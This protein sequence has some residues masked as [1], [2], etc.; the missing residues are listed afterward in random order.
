MFLLV[1][2]LIGA[3]MAIAGLVK[4]ASFST[5]PLEHVPALIADKRTHISGGGN[6]SSATTKYFA[7]LERADGSRSEVDVYGA[8]YGEIAAGDW[9]LACLRG[10][11]LL[12]FKRVGSR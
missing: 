7:T 8:R 1:F 11:V 6:D 12:D 5:S 9:G 2:V 10:G 3:C 4:L